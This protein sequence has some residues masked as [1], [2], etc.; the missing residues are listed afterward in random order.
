MRASTPEA[1]SM[2][3][4]CLYAIDQDASDNPRV[5]YVCAV[6]GMVL[7]FSNGGRCL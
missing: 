2:L 6:G 1:V 3:V 5:A 4:Q 7:G